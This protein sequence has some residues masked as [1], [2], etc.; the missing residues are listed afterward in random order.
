MSEWFPLP[1][2]GAETPERITQTLAELDEGRTNCCWKRKSPRS[3][4]KVRLTRFRGFE[5]AARR[6]S[7][8]FFP[9]RE[10]PRWLHTGLL[11][12]AVSSN[13]SKK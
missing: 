4:E 9:E 3:K 5:G 12:N 2:I 11:L 10:R 1:V 7:R 6:P 8:L 13:G